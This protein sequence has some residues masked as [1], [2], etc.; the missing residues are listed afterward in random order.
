MLSL[1]LRHKR[2]FHN[3]RRVLGNIQVFVDVKQG[4]FD[5]VQPLG[6]HL[7]AFVENHGHV[8]HVLGVVLVYLLQ[9]YFVLFLALLHLFL[10]LLN[11]VLH[12]LHLHSHKNIL[13]DS[14]DAH[15]ELPLR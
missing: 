5:E 10:R 13:N 3:L 11:A 4:R 6:L 12:L 7:L 14:L 8:L 2:N 1:L 9:P 15:R